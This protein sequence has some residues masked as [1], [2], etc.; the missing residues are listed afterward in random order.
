M[1]HQKDW[2]KELVVYQIYPRSFQDGNGDG[3]G[4][5]KG[6]IKRLDYLKEL[7][8]NAVW[9]SP[10]YA[11]PNVDNGYDISD[12][13]QIMEE[14][15]TMEDWEAFR[16]GAHQ[17]GIAIIMDLVLNHSSD[18]HEWFQESKKSKNN[19]YSDYYIW[20]DPSEDGKEPNGWMSV[21][22]GSAWEYVPERGQ[23]YLHF[24]AKEQPD[25]NWEND[26][27]RE[28]IFDIIRFWNEKGV[29][30]Y[31][32]D[33]ISYLD[34]GLDGRANREEAFG[35]ASC[36]NLEGTHRFIQEMVKK[37]IEP[38]HLMTVGEV[39]VNST[40]DAWNYTS[41][42][43]GEFNMAIPFI[44]PIVE[45]E[46]WSPEN[47][48]RNLVETYEATKEDGWWARFF[49]NHDKP[50]QVSLYGSDTTYWKES[51]KML[52]SFLHT[53]PGTPFVFQGE[54]LGMTNIKLPSIEDYDDID[55]KNYYKTM[56]EEGASEEEALRT[57]QNISRDNA[58][59]P[60][61]WDASENGG[62]TEGKPWLPVNPNYREINAA[63]QMED[64]D[65]IFRFYQ[66]LIRLRKEYPVLVHGDFRMLTEEEG[67]LIAFTRSLDGETW[68]SVH[69]FSAEDSFFRDDVLK[70][71][72][73][74]MLTNYGRTEVEEESI[75][76]KP[77]E[78]IVLKM[79]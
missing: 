28:K 21:F 70:G 65:S 66:K 46:T 27:A 30:G 69:N 41:A 67:K 22:G 75:W 58:R 71:D 55:T 20:R 78:T 56:V 53:L 26:E 39:I 16:D 52:A 61:Q 9:M 49:S 5:L 34:K 12:Y 25:L 37:T 51:A 17:R 7:G 43:R 15:G 44:P 47:I 14:F 33:A 36:A 59:T 60:M 8:I 3:V 29:D 62:F 54:E 50:R 45:I 76:L 77:Y 24:F 31:R 72:K 64:E 42:S 68:V 11:S 40:L 74:V 6:M 35:T 1:K 2:F 38:D 23:Y 10:V 57:S 48:K 18:L 63:K 79:Q 73:T 19:P 13:Y 32:I 4:D